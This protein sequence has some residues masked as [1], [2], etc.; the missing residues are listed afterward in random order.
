MGTQYPQNTVRTVP[1]GRNR[2][3]PAV[4]LD[5]GARGCQPALALCLDN[6]TIQQLLRAR[7]S[8]E[9]L[10]GKY[11]DIGEPQILGSQGM[12]SVS[13]LGSGKNRHSDLKQVL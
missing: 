9:L 4:T 8:P 6:T 5:T 7:H 13:L 11:T 1:A 10:E 2:A 12:H 3:A